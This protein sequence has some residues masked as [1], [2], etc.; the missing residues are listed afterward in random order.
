MKDENKKALQGEGMHMGIN[1]GC[2]GCC[3]IHE[4]IAILFEFGQN[5]MIHL[6]STYTCSELKIVKSHAK[7]TVFSFTANSPTTHVTPRSGSRTT[8]LFRV[9]LIWEKL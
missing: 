3:Y 4:A 6:C 9:V 8:V 5:A 1:A 7:T 2:S